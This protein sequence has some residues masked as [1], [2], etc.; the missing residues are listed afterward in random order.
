LLRPTLGLLGLLATSP[1]LPPLAQA[2]LT[3]EDQQAGHGSR[4]QPLEEDEER[5]HLAG[6]GQQ[7]IAIMPQDALTVVLQA[8]REAW[9]VQSPPPTR[10][11][12]QGGRRG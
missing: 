8:S 2:P 5:L 9:R 4:P 11:Y 10:K 7:A 3:G 6:G 1:R 12:L